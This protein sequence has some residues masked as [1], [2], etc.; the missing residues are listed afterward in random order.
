MIRRPCVAALCSEIRPNSHADVIVGRWLAPY[1][2]DAA[3]G[4]QNPASEIVSIYAQQRHPQRD[5][6][7]AWQER[8][9]IAM[10]DSIREALTLGGNTLAVDAVLLIAEHGDYPENEFGQKLYPRKEFFEEMVRVFQE[11]GRVVPVFLD[12]HLSWN[13]DWIREMWGTIESMGI[14]FFGGSSI[15]FSTQPPQQATLT[16]PRDTAAIFFGGLESYL[17]HAAELVECLGWGLPRGHI[18]VETAEGGQAWVAL[19]QD[20][21]CWS[22]L[23]AS[24]DVVG[25]AGVLETLRAERNTDV[26]LFSFTAEDGSRLRFFREPNRIRKWAAATRTAEAKSPIATAADTRGHPGFHPHFARL[27]VAIDRFFQTGETPFSS[28]RILT[29]SLLTAQAMRARPSNTGSFTLP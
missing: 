24:A 17:F 29:T 14:P 11:S 12:K 16:S 25:M 22:L 8:H 13:P 15:P 3:V 23:L 21:D 7:P 27:C 10:Y 19:E 5:L 1:P 6:L 4:W 26:A 18:E 2:S 20:A 9:G 28:S